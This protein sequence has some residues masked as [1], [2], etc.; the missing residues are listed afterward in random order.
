[1]RQLTGA[2]RMTIDP[3]SMHACLRLSYPLVNSLACA[4]NCA[5]V[6][7]GYSRMIDLCAAHLGERREATH[8]GDI[9][10]HKDTAVNVEV[11]AHHLADQLW[12]LRPDA[13]AL[14]ASLSFSS[15]EQELAPATNMQLFWL[16]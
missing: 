13:H 16:G 1:M 6:L 9:C 12:A 7:M 8:L 14:P 2:I 4:M 10:A 5:S 3:V 11:L 15:S